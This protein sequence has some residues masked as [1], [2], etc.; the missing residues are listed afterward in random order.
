MAFKTKEEFYGTM[1][2][3]SVLFDN[4]FNNYDQ[5]LFKYAGVDF[6][7]MM[8][9]LRSE[10]GDVKVLIRDMSFLI[11]LTQV[12]GVNIEKISSKSSDE[13]KRE[14]RKIQSK[15][16]IVKHH[17]NLPMTQPSLPRLMS[18]FPQQIYNFR[19]KHS[20]PAVGI[21]NGLDSGLAWPG[22]LA[23]VNPSDNDRIAKFKLWY[24][25]FCSVV[26]IE[27]KEEN[28]LIALNNSPVKMVDRL[29]LGV[30]I[31]TATKSTVV[32]PS[33]YGS[34]APPVTMSK[35]TIPTSTTSFG[36]SSPM[37]SP[38]SSKKLMTRPEKIE[39][40]YNQI[41]TSGLDMSTEVI[42]VEFVNLTD[43]V[44]ATLDPTKASLAKDLVSKFVTGE[45][46]P[47]DSTL[48]SAL[49]S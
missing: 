17:K 29:P 26:K 33:S 9:H 32:T 25:S 38:K 22:G 46:R 24:Q 41:L 18:L 23:M 39:M 45:E 19:V 47:L 21:L 43:M 49:L 13:L 30:A 2:A 28:C 12:R 8:N 34:F 42:G 35:L 11:M 6:L 15:Y 4:E 20:I 31:A 1:N 5:E 44:I 16:S 10:E 27:F 48:Y 3:Q 14:L 7:V 36:S 40:L 37:S